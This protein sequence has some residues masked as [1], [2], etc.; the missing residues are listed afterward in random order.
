MRIADKFSLVRSLYHKNNVHDD[1]SHWVQTGYPL[2]GAR[3]RG[4]QHPAQG[5]V[6]SHLRGA[7][8]AD[9]PPYVCIP[10]AYSSRK[11][12]YQQATYLRAA[13]IR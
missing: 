2:T 6:V 4:Q 5:A 12:F 7:R 3:E 1:A 10:E 11:G 8:Q 13:A 9:I